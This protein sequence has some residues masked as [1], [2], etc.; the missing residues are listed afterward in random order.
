MSK[1]TDLIAPVQTPYLLCGANV[2]MPGLGTMIQACVNAEGFNRKTFGLG[3]FIHFLF[4]L[5]FAQWPV[6]ACLAAVMTAL[7]L[8]CDFCIDVATIA[9]HVA[10]MFG[11]VFTSLCCCLWPVW[12]AFWFFEFFM[13]CTTQPVRLACMMLFWGMCW[14]M[15]WLTMFTLHIG[16]RA[17]HMWHDYQTI[18]M[19]EAKLGNGM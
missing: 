18:K 16:A 1:A 8:A 15:P 3:L 2:L 5:G 9:V 12:W 7:M 4:F 6:H 14:M 11:C 13:Q 19:S 10:S 17:I